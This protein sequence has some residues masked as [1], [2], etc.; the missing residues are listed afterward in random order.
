MTKHV[1]YTLPSR[2]VLVST[3][4]EGRNSVAYPQTKARARMIAGAEVE[5]GAPT[6]M[7][8]T[9]HIESFFGRKQKSK[10]L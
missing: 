10:S 6:I 1:L 7:A 2:Y 3:D 9:H 5:E 8:M 4:D